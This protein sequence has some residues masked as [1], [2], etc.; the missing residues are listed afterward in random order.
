[1]DRKWV[2]EVGVE[3]DRRGGRGRRGRVEEIG[4]KR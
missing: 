3:R 1:M 2:E 4:G